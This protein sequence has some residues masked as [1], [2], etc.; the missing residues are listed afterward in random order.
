M[1]GDRKEGKIKMNLKNQI[2]AYAL[3]N[4]IH[5]NRA[6]ENVVLPKLFLHG[7][8]KQDIKKIIP[9]IKKAVTKINSMKKF[10]IEKQF[11]KYSK[12]LKKRGHKQPTELRELPNTNRSMV[13]R[14]APFPSGALHI[15]NARTYLLNALYAEKYHGKVLLVIDD[16]IGSVKKQIMPEAYKLIEDG[17]QW[18]GIKYHKNIIYKSD[19]LEIYYKYAEKL[20]KFNKAYVCSCSAEKLRENRK[21][22]RACNCRNNKPE[23]N[24][25]LWRKMFDSKTKPGDYS[26]RIKTNMK[27]EDPAFRDRVLFRI[28][29]RPHP[30][31]NKKYR[32]WPL[33]DFS[34][35][36]DDKLLG[37]THIIR[38]KDLMMET[39]MEKFIFD[40]FSW[41]HPEFIHIGLMK[42][43]GVKGAKISKSKAQEEVASGKFIGWDDPRTLSIQ[44]LRRV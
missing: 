39:M 19:R 33:L 36:I 22:G 27:H 11:K 31:V 41:K 15:G 42:I 32:V 40:I 20:I 38:G 23:K 37:I 25:E 16:T 24:L 29:D 13:F 30:R 17:F 18:L 26:L 5:F 3:E 43:Q 10:E 1:C 6:K 14:L 12:Y 7:L 9:E 2:Y 4:A 8:K 35:A 34:W 28:S 21:K 44:S